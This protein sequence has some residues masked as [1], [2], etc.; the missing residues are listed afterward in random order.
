MKH[1]LLISAYKDF[2][3][4]IKMLEYYKNYFDC[5]IHIDKKSKGY[6]KLYEYANEVDNIHVFRKYRINWGSYKH[7]SAFLLLMRE[8]K[9]CDDYDYYHIISANTFITKPYSEF[10]DFFNKHQK[11]NF[12]EIENVS[13]DYF[14]NRFKYYHFLHIYNLK[15][16]VGLII[17]RLVVKIQKT[18]NVTTK[19]IFNFKGYIYCHLNKKFVNYV[20]EYVQNNKYINSLK[21]CDIPEEF[22]FQNIIMCSEYKDNIIND[23]LIYSIWNGNLPNPKTIDINDITKILSDNSF[24][25]RKIESVD[26]LNSIIN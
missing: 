22:F 2:D 14:V 3:I 5:Y 16:P 23:S 18:F 24:F 10:D 25:A 20:L 6:S 21:T 8:A 9:K 15:T 12:I 4:L 26:V 1:A 17:D 19:R 11:D 13:D 7:I